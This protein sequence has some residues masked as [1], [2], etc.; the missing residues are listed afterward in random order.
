MVMLLIFG[1]D[2][3]RN[4]ALPLCIGIVCGCYSSVCISGPLWNLFRGKKKD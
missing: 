4:F 3:I 2:S 1:V